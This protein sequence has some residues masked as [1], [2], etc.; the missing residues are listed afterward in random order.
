M[1]PV[2]K[3]GIHVENVQLFMVLFLKLFCRFVSFKMKSWKELES[4]L[5]SWTQEIILGIWFLLNLSA[6]YL[7]TPGLPCTSHPH[8]STVSRSHHAF[9]L[10]SAM[11]HVVPPTTK[12]FLPFHA[13]T[14]E[15]PLNVSQTRL[16]VREIPFL[17]TP[18]LCLQ[19]WVPTSIISCTLLWDM[20]C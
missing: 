4:S 8:L 16:F 9:P 14:S 19:A 7:V 12:G 2:N 17:H 15:F 18:P 1:A 13:I 11:A 6:L 20:N 10:C 3:L 5:C